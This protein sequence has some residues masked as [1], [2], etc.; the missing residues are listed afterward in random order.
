M[1]PVELF[2]GTNGDVHCLH[3]DVVH[4]LDL[5]KPTIERASTIEFSNENQRWEVAIDGTMVHHAP[6]RQQ[7]LDWEHE[8]LNRQLER[9]VS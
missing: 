7:C 5:G 8:T 3:A 2:I 1:K 4:E 6:T 9:T